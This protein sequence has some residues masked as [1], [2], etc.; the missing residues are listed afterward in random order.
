[1]TST[2]TLNLRY[3]KSDAYGNHIF[4]ASHKYPEELEAFN[5]L[6]E[7]ESKLKGLKTVKFLPVFSN[8]DI[9]YAT[10]R[11]KYCTGV[12][13]VARNTYTIS[14]N[15]SQTNGVKRF[16]NCNVKSIKFHSEAKKVDVG[17][18]LDIF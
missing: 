4:I 1:M 15:I 13:L 9:G 8:K 5:R 16:I 2:I 10:V 14:F 7:V 3:Q 17:T 12:K 6:V 18:V 11:F